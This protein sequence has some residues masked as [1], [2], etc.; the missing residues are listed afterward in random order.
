MPG[1]TTIITRLLTPALL[2]VGLTAAPGIALAATPAPATA[3]ASADP[4]DPF[5]V[6]SGSTPLANLEPGAVLDIR[7]VPF[8]LSGLPTPIQTVQILYRSTDQLGRPIANVTSVIRPLLT[9]PTNAIS[10]Q[11]FYDSL[12]PEDGPSRTI[13]GRVDSGGFI[14]TFETNLFIDYLAQGYAVIVPDTEGP[15]A[16]FAAGPQYGVL[17]LDSIR[18]ASQA[19][20]TGITAETRVGML[21]YS[22][23][24]IATGWAATLAPLYAP[25]VNE[26]IVGA[27]EG[28][29]LVTPAHNLTYISGTPMWGGVIGMAIIGVGRAFDIDFTPYLNEEGKA[30]LQKMKDASIGEV[31]GQ[32][33]NFTFERYVKPEFADPNSI[34]PYVD[35]VNK[36]NLG[37]YPSP[38]V[39]MQMR[40]GAGG[41]AEQTPGNQP[42]IGPG[43]G[44][45]I[46]GDVRALAKQYCED[47]TAVD[48]AEYAPLSHFSSMSTWAPEAKAFLAARFANTPFVG[49][50]ESIAAGNSLAPEVYRPGPGER[51]VRTKSKIRLPKVWQV[52]G[53]ESTRVRFGVVSA[54]RPTR[55]AKGG[56]ATVR[57]DGKV[58]KRT[59]VPVKNPSSPKVLSARVRV[60]K[61]LPLGKHQ[62]DLSFEPADDSTHRASA[63]RTVV[64]KVVQ[65]RPK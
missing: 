37:S 45:M 39:P 54:K 9:E 28:G 60:P 31:L 22:G 51:P 15:D 61:N 50:C 49:N 5:F 36:L 12:D 52:R 34:K 62:L 40:Q 57:L 46:L 58:L 27:A 32:Y 25:D 64:L 7:T 4:E 44:V 41:E 48:Y 1:L 10:Y 33:P 26:R 59:R 20:G 8:S 38:T 6:Y 21:G 24:A 19:T 23:G 35:A 16:D 55:G 63:S 17:T 65:K 14:V 47:G 29:V 2:S 53:K 30:V 11:S 18:A 56:W 13:A 3:P 42:G 43:D